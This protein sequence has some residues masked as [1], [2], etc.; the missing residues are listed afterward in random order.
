MGGVTDFL[1]H[2][3]GWL[4]LILWASFA[5]V[6]LK[7]LLVAFPILPLYLRARLVGLRIGW[8]ELIGMRLRN[9]VAGTRSIVGALIS[10]KVQRLEVNP[11]DVEALHLAQGDVG[12]VVMTLGWA[13]KAEVP[14]T[15][16]E[17][18]ALDLMGL[19]KELMD[20]VL[21]AKESKDPAKV[22]ELRS[23]LTAAT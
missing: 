21:A 22:D 1:L 19:G 11:I 20:A 5:Y 10:A 4:I 2:P 23:R 15:W 6:L 3:P 18:S 13:R 14:L 7:L 17:A 8:L 12:R 9:G 16:K